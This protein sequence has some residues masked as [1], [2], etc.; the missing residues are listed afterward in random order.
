MYVIRLTN[1]NLQVPHSA[2]AG[3]TGSAEDGRIIG[4]GYVE[5]GPDDPDYERLLGQ[6]LTPEEL[7]GKRREWR[8]GDEALLHE[9]E[10]WKARQD[11]D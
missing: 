11:G 10:E 8:V 1:G 7:E 6:A 4:Q 2:V 9:F 3:H 5:I